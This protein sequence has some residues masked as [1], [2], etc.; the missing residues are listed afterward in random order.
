MTTRSSRQHIGGWI[1]A[2][3][4]GSACL[5]LWAQS[6]PL[7]ANPPAA[8]E[9]HPMERMNAQ[10]QRHLQALKSKLQLTAEQEPAWSA[11]TGAMTPPARPAMA[12]RQAQQAEMAKLPTPERIDR[13][14]T[15]R[16][17]RQAEMNAQAERRGQASKTFYASLR[18]EQK[19]V[20]DEETARLMGPRHGPQSHGGRHRHG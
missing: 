3:L 16:E 17:Q 12:D 20:F 13:M 19:K 7:G 2:A 1:T 15:L 14:K 8:A 18:T 6:A 5:N 11:F 4:L 10:H 9:R